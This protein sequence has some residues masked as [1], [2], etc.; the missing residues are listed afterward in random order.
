MDFIIWMFKLGAIIFIATTVFSIAMGAII[1]LFSG[2]ISLIS[3]AGGSK[4]E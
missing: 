3:K 2:I 1:T 4:K